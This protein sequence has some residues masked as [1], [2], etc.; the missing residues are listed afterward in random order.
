M[1]AE[2]LYESLL[3]ATEAQARRG[4]LRTAGSRARASGWSSSPS[5]LAPTT[6]S[7]TTTFN[8]TIPQTLMMMNGDLMQ[9]AT[10]IEKGS[11]LHRIAGDARIN[12]AAK[13]KHLYLAALAR[14]PSG[15]EISLAN[16]LLVLRRGDGRRPARRMVGDAEQQ[17]VHFEPLSFFTLPP[18]CERLP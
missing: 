3:V 2:E 15:H 12:N 9:Q 1:R 13:I 5:L 18:V 11:F 17:R 10:S 4:Q 16:E 6:T 7:E 14:M 8:G